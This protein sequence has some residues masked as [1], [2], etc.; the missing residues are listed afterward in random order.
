MSSFIGVRE[1]PEAVAEP[2]ARL[3][4]PQAA[5]PRL[6]DAEPAQL[7]RGPDASCTRS[8]TS[9][10][11]GS[12]SRRRRRISSGSSSTARAGACTS[13]PSSSTRSSS[14]RTTR[15]ARGRAGRCR[16]TPAPT[17]GCDYLGENVEDYKRRFEIKTGRRPEGLEGPDRALQ[18]PEPD[19]PGPAG[20]GPEADPRHRRRALVPGAG[21]RPDQRRRLLDPRQRLQHLP[22][23]AGASSTS[24]RTT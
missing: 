4:R 2:V 20:G 17:A 6:Q 12:T 9:T 21:Q 8:S 14:P 23:R 15:A 3:R 11:P 19:A 24:S 7:A 10:S 16:G 5:A 1:G 22:R 13:T 18:G